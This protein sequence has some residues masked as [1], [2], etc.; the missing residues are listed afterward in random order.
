MDGQDTV[1]ILKAAL[2]AAEKHAP[3]KRK[4]VAEEPYVNHLLE[5]AFLLAEATGGADTDLIIAGLLH[6]TVED[7]GV[8]GQQ[9]EQEFGADVAGLVSEVTD[10]KSL[11]KEERKRLQVVNAPHKSPRAKM[12]KLADKT[13]NLRAITCSPPKDW[14][15]ERKRAYFEWARQVVEGCRGVHAGLEQWFDCAYS[16]GL[17]VLDRQ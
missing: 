9:L 6:D 11:P 5:V 1:R 10:D 7:Q 17:S 4:G 16:D 2:F 8:T 3:Q 13:S 12:L 15:L 14:P